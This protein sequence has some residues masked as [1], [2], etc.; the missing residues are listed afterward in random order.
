MNIESKNLEIINDK[1]D[2]QSKIL[3]TKSQKVLFEFFDEM[4]KFN[5][6]ADLEKFYDIYSHIPAVLK[7]NN[8][9]L[10]L[11]CVKVV[12][13]NNNMEIFDKK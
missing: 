11:D 12:D 10:H 5:P 2:A 8:L 7:I 13:A 6:D 4:I 1:N 9:P 3:L